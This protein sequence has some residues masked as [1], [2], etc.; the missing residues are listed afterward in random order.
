MER[1][2]RIASIAWNS[3]PALRAK[4]TAPRAGGLKYD[5]FKRPTPNGPNDYPS[6]HAVAGSW[7]IRCEDFQNLGDQYSF[8]DYPFSLN[9]VVRDDGEIEGDFNFGPWARGFLRSYKP[10]MCHRS[11]TDPGEVEYEAPVE[12]VGY[13]DDH[14]VIAPDRGKRLGQLRF[15]KHDDLAGDV[16][17]EGYLLAMPGCEKDG[18]DFDGVW[19]G[20]LARTRLRG[21]TSLQPV[22]RHRLQIELPSPT[23]PS[24][25]P[26]RPHAG[27][28][29]LA[30]SRLGCPL[31]DLF[32]SRTSWL[33]RGPFDAITSRACA[34]STT[35]IHSS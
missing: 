31:G 35:N 12:W 30:L 8:N 26:S 25:E 22:I 10:T 19:E 29:V 2:C 21:M 1:A 13:R 3:T 7:S 34:T 18:I 14:G 4:Q 5:A 11:R 23:S 27:L 17:L 15:Y 20:R 33:G 24:L 32:L 16:V 9:I 28:E 6:P